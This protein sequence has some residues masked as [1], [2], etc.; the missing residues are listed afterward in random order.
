MRFSVTTVDFTVQGYERLRSQDEFILT[1]YPSKGETGADVLDELIA[2]L[3]AYARPDAFDYAAAEAALRAYFDRATIEGL[4]AEIE[5]VFGQ[6]DSDAEEE[7]EPDAVGPIVF[8][9]VHATVE[10]EDLKTAFA[11]AMA[12][13]TLAAPTESA[14]APDGGFRASL[15]LGPAHVGDVSVFPDG[16]P[17]RLLYRANE[18]AREDGTIRTWWMSNDFADADALRKELGL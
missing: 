9:Y 4:T 17:V 3:D 13:L 6:I 7:A 8:C 5:A 1:A 15:W 12:P 18:K 11:S 16:G 14:S 2:D 10:P